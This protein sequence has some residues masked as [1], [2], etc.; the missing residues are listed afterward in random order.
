MFQEWFFVV[1]GTKAARDA[2]KVAMNIKHE[3][4]ALVDPF[5]ELS[6]AKGVEMFAE[7]IPGVL[8]QTAAILY[9][10]ESG[11]GTTSIVSILI[12][13]LTTGFT[14][15]QI[16]YDFDTAP[17]ER[18]KNPF[19]YGY[20]PDDSRARTILFVAMT[21]NPAFMLLIKR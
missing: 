17:E 21:L 16:S 20:V 14:S 5:F 9:N 12:S 15:A 19:F 6:F 11:F 7:S 13:S 4:G 3:E 18:A 10:P 1:T 8:I 2:Y